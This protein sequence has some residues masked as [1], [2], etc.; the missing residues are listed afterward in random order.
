MFKVLQGLGT[1][2]RESLKNRRAR[3][4]KWC[5][6]QS[7]TSSVHNIFSLGHLPCRT[8]SSMQDMALKLDL[9]LAAI[10]GT[11]PTLNWVCQ[12]AEVDQV[13]AHGP[14]PSLLNCQLLLDAEGDNYYLHL[15]TN[16]EPLGSNGYFH[17]WP[18]IR[19]YLKSMDHK[20]KQRHE[21]GKGTCRKWM[22]PG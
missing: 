22:V 4:G 14:Y 13:E 15:C 19:T 6:L 11:R 1:L 3:G 8:S 18:H 16:H 20:I 2:Q 5:S 10:E 21:H 7:A 12:Q 17:S 9:T